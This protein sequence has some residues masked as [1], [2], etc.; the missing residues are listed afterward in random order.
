LDYQEKFDRMLAEKIMMED[1]ESGYFYNARKNVTNL[2]KGVS[3][4][5]FYS[6]YVLVNFEFL[7]RF[8]ANSPPQLG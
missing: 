2:R 5:F 7:M 4:D 8:V 1:P 3:R 6:F